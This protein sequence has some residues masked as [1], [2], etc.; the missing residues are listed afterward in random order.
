MPR[1]TQDC[2]AWMFATPVPGTSWPLQPTPCECGTGGTS[3]EQG[4]RK[5]TLDDP[6]LSARCWEW[7][8]P[9]MTVGMKMKWGSGRQI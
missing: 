3:V 4:Q 8:L 2:K 7:S 9:Y 1:E 5:V 6:R